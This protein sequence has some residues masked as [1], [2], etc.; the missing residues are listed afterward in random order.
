LHT[1]LEEELILS[2]QHEDI[3]KRI[4]SVLVVKRGR[5]I[6]EAKIGEEPS[7]MSVKII[8]CS[9]GAIPLELIWPQDR[10]TRSFR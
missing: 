10:T 6:T 2:V 4:G 7:T 1:T 9:P 3:W 8:L 5:V